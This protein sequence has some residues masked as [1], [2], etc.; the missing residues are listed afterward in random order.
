MLDD[1]KNID[2]YLELS[3]TVKKKRFGGLL[4]DE[5]EENNLICKVFLFKD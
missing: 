4:K 2:N 5:E 3:T 1:Y